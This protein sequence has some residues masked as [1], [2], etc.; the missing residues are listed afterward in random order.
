MSNEEH[1][2]QSREVWSTADSTYGNEHDHIGQDSHGSLQEQCL[3][4]SQT[5]VPEHSDAS[6]VLLEDNSDVPPSPT[7]S[8]SW[9]ID[10]TLSN[11]LFQIFQSP[12]EEIAFNYFF[13]RVCTCIPAHDSTK[14]PWRNLALVSLSHPV[15]LHGILSVATAH[16]HNCGRSNV[17][18]LSSRQSR[19]LHS[20]QAALNALQESRE[21]HRDIGKSPD[22]LLLQ[23]GVFSILSATEIALAAVM[24][25]TSSVLMTGAGNVEMHLKCALHFI[26]D[27]GYLYHPPDSIFSRTLVNRFAMVDVV[28]AHLR[29]RRPLASF[30]FFMYQE[31]EKLDHGDPAFREM[32]GCD[33]RVLC[34]LAE[35][36]VLSADLLDG[37]TTHDLVQAKAYTLETEMRIWGHKYDNSMIRGASMSKAATQASFSRPSALSLSGISILDIVCECFYW[38]AQLLLLRRLFLDPTKS[39]R[40][41]LVRRHLFQI[42]DKLE[43]GCG[44][45]SSLPFPF[46]MAAREATTLEERNWV[47]R[48]HAAM[49]EVYRDRSREYMMEY[50]E[51]IWNN[52]ASAE[53]SSASNDTLSWRTPREQYIR[54]LDKQSTYFMF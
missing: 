20:L 7:N 24:M 22:K 17:S 43:P 19:A 25:Q 18:V 26:Q 6:L 50:T 2:E 48:K 8:T 23:G 38:T 33:Q 12:G 30:D 4:D 11:L 27:L 42:M 10:N 34:F 47:R 37:R 15:L 46:Y 52:A 5:I 39:S 35:I 1:F 51:K 36:A 13:K 45:D 3:V 44:P 53:N 21:R 41:Q 29:F 31:N 14:N 9:V 16:M 54:D 49:M 40:V 32:H 28:H